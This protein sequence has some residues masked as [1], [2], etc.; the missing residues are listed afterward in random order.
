MLKVHI[1]SICFQCNG[2]AYVPIGEAEDC[3]GHKYSR[4]APCPHCEGSGN[5]SKWVDLE[6]FAKLMQ[7]SECPHKHTSYQGSMRFT[8]G[9]VW[10]DIQEVCDD[11]RANLDR[12][13]LSN[14]INDE[15]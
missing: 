11:C 2:K 10:D 14:Y 8:S 7:Q 13:T 12:Q 1:L 6:D 3:Q 5:E 15:N 9:D 4:Y